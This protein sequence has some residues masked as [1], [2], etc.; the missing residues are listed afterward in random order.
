MKNLR[1]IIFL[2]A[3]LACTIQSMQAYEYFTIY[4][5]DGTKSEPFYATDV[6]SIR[7]SKLDV[8]S[9]EYANWQVQEIWTVDSVFRYPL[10]AIANLSFTDVDENK[11]AEDIA[12][13]SAEIAPIYAQCNSTEEI[14]QNLSTIL[15]VSGVEN[16]WT[17]NQSL[18]VKIRNWG[19]MS[20]SYPPEDD[21]DD[22]EN[23]ST[24]S[25][26][27]SINKAQSQTSEYKA[28]IVNQMANDEKR[29]R[30]AK[31]ASS[32]Q[33]KF[34][35]MGIKST[36]YNKPLPSFFQNEIFEY[37]LV[38]LMTHG[39]YDGKNHWLFTGEE[40]MCSGEAKTVKKKDFQKLDSIALN[41]FN[42]KYPKH[43]ADKL[44]LGWVKEK[45]NGVIVLVWYTMISEHYIAAAK[46]NYNNMDAVV[47]N[48]SCQSLKGGNGFGN[49]FLRKGAK[50]YLGYTETNSIGAEG[51]E[52]FFNNL[53]NG[54]S[55][56]G[57]IK[58]I[59]PKWCSQTRKDG[60]KPQLLLLS[61]KNDAYNYHITDVI[62][63][64]AEQQDD[65]GVKL[66]AQYKILDPY[67]EGSKGNR[68][69][70]IYSESSNPN[71]NNGKII[72]G[73]LDY[74][75]QSHIVGLEG[76]IKN[77]ELTPNTTYYYRAF[78]N[79]GYSDCL[80]E[81]KSFTTNDDS[82]S[83]E[84]TS[85]Y[86]AYFVLKD[87][88][89]T[90]YY[91]DKIKER[92]GSDLD[93]VNGYYHANFVR[94]IRKVIIDPSFAKYPQGFGF[95]KFTNLS[96]IENIQYLNTSN[97]TGMSYMFCEC[98]SLTT[99]DL[100][101]LNTS[102]VT[103]M[104]YM[105]YKCYSL[106]NLNMS[107]INMENVWT[108]KRMFEGC[109]SLTHLDMSNCKTR[110]LANTDYM[111]SGCSSL[112]NLDVSSF[113]TSNV[114]DMS[115]MFASC[116]SLTSLDLSSFNTSN[117]K[118]MGGMF[119]GCSS[120]KSLNLSS[121]NTS[122]VTSM[123]YMFSGCSS[124]TSLDLSGFS[125]RESRFHES[126]FENCSSLVT[127]YARNWIGS[128]AKMFRGCNNLVGGQGTKIGYNIYDYDNQGNPLVY[129]CG[130]NIGGARIDGGKDNPGLFTAK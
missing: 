83:E 121:F 30:P 110:D 78:M 52:W 60:T 58:T 80:G 82:G 14:Y 99:L 63:L 50:G 117:V 6:D 56:Y 5:T 108:T 7:Y 27:F 81:V 93:N 109:Y 89:C 111:F 71:T 73:N 126:M 122:N 59:P 21:E 41:L 98:E 51:G 12:S 54:K 1:R 120:L 44:S 90:L 18:F 112:T 26:Q 105:F 62:T 125:T 64:P 11:V 85:T 4:F 79:D 95:Y 97:V 16:A 36:P 75:T 48:L 25:K 24:Y 123:D 66:N 92:E 87:S 40:L 114:T 94:Q 91:D 113:N 86:K 101:S 65:S 33:Q 31:A 103:Q 61:Q 19:I 129:I 10:S 13:V 37:D 100:R 74:N 88:I 22:I 9:I 35:K 43:S 84:D 47:F 15:N 20:F 127:I 69:G 124:L 96:T 128:G 107:N 39:E 115:G 53:L 77:N 38:F 55:A 42:K 49:T 119:I 106:R 3:V 116:S 118:N 104:D 2:L 17:D 29:T 130:T 72:G 32:I 57:A 45:R 28:C 34:D 102:K 67:S 76:I 70:F 46:R 68:Y 8:D 23:L